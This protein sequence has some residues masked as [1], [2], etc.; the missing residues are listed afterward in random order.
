MSWQFTWEGVF[1]GI[2]G[3]RNIVKYMPDVVRSNEKRGKAMEKPVDIIE[4]LISASAN[5]GTTI[6]D[7]FMGRGSA[8]M[9]CKNLGME[10]I[11]I[12]IE[13]DIF[14]VAT[15]RIEAC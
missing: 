11:G 15:K 5:P 7:P 1:Y 8:G 12:E 10:F 2:K 6:L 13:P 4:K 9:A 3:K 14:E